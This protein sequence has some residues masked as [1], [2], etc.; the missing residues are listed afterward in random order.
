[1]NATV[2]TPPALPH[3]PR[4]EHSVPW[5]WPMAAAIELDEDGLRLFAD[6]LR[7]LD[8]ALEISVPHAPRWATPNRIRLDLPTMRLRDFRGAR[9]P[10]APPRAPVLVDAPYAGHSSTIADFAKGQSLV[11]TLQE[12]GLDEVFVT[13]WKSA[14]PA[15]KD[16]SIDSYL[17]DLDAAVARLGDSVDLVG[18]CQGGWLCAMYAA[19]FPHKVRTLVLAGA[20]IDTD[21]GSGPV[22]RLAHSLPLSFYEELVR[23]GG[24][25]M[26]GAA[27][28]AG[29]KSLNPQQQYLGKYLELYR[30]IEDRNYI[31]RTDAFERWYETTL[32]LPGVYYLQAIEWLF[33]ENRLAKGEFVGLG[34]RLSLGDIVCPVYLLAGADDTITTREQVFDATRYLGTPPARIVTR[35]APGGH[36]G[37]FMG[38][39]TLHE[40]WPDIA[41]WI[42]AVASHTC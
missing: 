11:A 32:D 34:R 42:L 17:L 10:S 41:H 25:R 2:P 20:P 31:A 16:F 30:H 3:Q 38:Q 14:T 33:K 22:K 28:L 37:L 40:C 5:F 24:G 23:L 6:N 12:N 15:M 19:R 35:L 13:D 29:W 1:M 9:R 4:H 8:Q 21:A 39:R 27:M 26:R 7:F 18:L 36:I